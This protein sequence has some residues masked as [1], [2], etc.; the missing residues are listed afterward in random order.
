M[1]ESVAAGKGSLSQYA[2]IPVLSFG[3]PLIVRFPLMVI[4]LAP[5]GGSFG[6]GTKGLGLG[7]FEAQTS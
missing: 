7:G 5:F 6:G 4:N 3:F 1:V 2:T